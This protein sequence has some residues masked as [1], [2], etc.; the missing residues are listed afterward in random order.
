MNRGKL[1][2]E[3]IVEKALKFYAEKI[4]VIDRWKYGL[5][6][7]EFFEVWKDCLV[8]IPPIVY[9]R[10]AKFRRDFE[11]KIPKRKISVAIANS[12]KNSEIKR[13]ENFFSSFFNIPVFSLEKVVNE[14]YDAIMQILTN[15]SD[16]ITITFRLMPHMVE[17]GPQIDVSHFVWE[18]T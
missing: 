12:K 15:F 6:R 16:H 3:G 13:I 17:I 2:L 4:I 14:R 8:H 9:V 7:I 10:C 1:S 18:L 11:E 5:A